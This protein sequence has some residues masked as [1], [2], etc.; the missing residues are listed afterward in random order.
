MLSRNTYNK[1]IAMI[2]FTNILQEANFTDPNFKRFCTKS[3]YIS[4]INNFAVY[5][6]IDSH[7]ERMVQMNE[8]Y[9]ENDTKKRLM[10][11]I[12]SDAE[13]GLKY[14]GINC[15]LFKDKWLIQ[16]IDFYFQKNDVLTTIPSSLLP[17]YFADSSIALY[18][19]P[20]S[21]SI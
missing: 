1:S 17:K 11:K 16:S 18:L 6:M 3:F 9:S 2:L 19:I 8:T 7:I 14:A 20:L 12:Y 4:L 5:K 13:L 10:I 15:I 21:N